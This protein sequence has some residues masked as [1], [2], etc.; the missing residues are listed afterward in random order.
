MKIKVAGVAGL[1]LALVAGYAN[2]QRDFSAVEVKAEHVAG[3]VHYLEG[4]GGN[5]GVFAGEDGVFLVD[6]QFAPLTEKIVAAIKGISDREIRFLI[7][8]HMHGD[9]TGGNENFGKMGTLI[10]AHDNV[11]ERL[12]A[13]SQPHG[14]LPVV[15]YSTDVKFHINGESVEVFKVPPAHTDGDSFVYFPESN[16]LHLGDVFRTVSYP[17]IDTGRGGTFTGTM[18]ALNIALEMSDANTIWIPGHGKPTSLEGAKEVIGILE[19]IESRVAALK[20]EGMSAE[21]IIARGV[22]QEW[23]ERLQGQGQFGKIESLIEVIYSELD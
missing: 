17:Y 23:D 13:E 21:Q 4:A 18:A 3:K 6:D 8:T 10:F 15:T 11:R 7:N 22:S 5:I 16:V 14:A 20:E 1:G 2:A 19:T 9:H 12:A